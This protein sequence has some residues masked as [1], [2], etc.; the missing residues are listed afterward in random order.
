MTMKPLAVSREACA[1]YE[2][3]SRLEWL[4]TNGTGGFAMGTV[5]GVNTRRYHGLLVSAERQMLLSR[6]EETADGVSLSTVQYPGLLALRGFERIAE[7]R[8]EPWPAWSFD[9]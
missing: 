3:G 8:S 4:E 1:D 9:N 7:F 5:A 6:L 2:R